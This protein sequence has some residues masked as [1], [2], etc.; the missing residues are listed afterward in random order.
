MQKKIIALAVAGLV[1][2][3]AFAQSNV[4]VYGVADAYYSYSKGDSA[5]FSGVNS[6]GLNGGRIGFKG[7]EALGNGLKA[8]FLYEFGSVNIDQNAG[9]TG[10]R[11]SF[12][13]LASDKMGTLSLGRQA[14][15]SYMFL[16]STS[17]NDVTAV[18][19]TNYY[20]PA[21]TTMNTG[22]GGRWNNSI[23]YS[24]PTMGGF[25]VRVIYGFGEQVDS[26][27]VAA[28]PA[29]PG[30]AGTAAAA[31]RDQDTGDLGQFGLGVRYMNGPIY[32][33]AMYQGIEDNGATAADDKN[34]AWAVGGNYDFKIV[35]VFANY[36]E[37]KL[38][39]ST[40]DV[41]KKVWS[42]GVAVPVS[43]VG[44][45]KIEYAQ[46]KGE[47]AVN[48]AT[49]KGFGIQYDHDLS[50]RTRLYAGIS[51]ITNDTG[52]AFGGQNGS[53]NGT[54][55]ISGS[56]NNVATSGKDNTNLVLGVRHFF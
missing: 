19:P 33:T 56:G 52:L 45:V 39:V 18:N 53:G 37:E 30:N 24:S 27:A 4:T 16:G 51:R 10:T 11:L 22:G 7:E 5:T 1:S 41:K 34:T 44:A 8:V 25:D 31:A 38:V 28:V 29:V 55:S 47:G 46:Y 42:L 15:P 13:G 35:K 32:L 43:S 20:I 48:D 49:S 26:P 17:S 21:M 23:A 36:V 40:V 9:L 3:V 54:A 12:V 50:K 2:G 14:S 6:G